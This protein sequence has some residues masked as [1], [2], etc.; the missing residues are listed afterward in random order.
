MGN[1]F[2]PKVIRSIVKEF[3]LK[4]HRNA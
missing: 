4:I 1:G 3:T 2:T